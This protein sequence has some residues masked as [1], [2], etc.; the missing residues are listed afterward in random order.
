MSTH[1]VGVSWS[2]VQL[3]EQDTPSKTSRHGKLLDM[4]DICEKLRE[5]SAMSTGQTSQVAKEKVYE[6]ARLDK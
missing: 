2:E 6:T 4:L 3:T 1:P 5:V